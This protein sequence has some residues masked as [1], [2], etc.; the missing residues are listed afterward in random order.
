MRSVDGTPD[1]IELP[2]SPSR[3]SP[4]PRTSSSGRKRT[5]TDADIFHDGD[6]SDSDEA[7]NRPAPRANPLT[8]QTFSNIIKPNGEERMSRVAKRYRLDAA[9]TTEL[10]AFEK[11]MFYV[12]RCRPC[13]EFAYTSYSSLSRINYFISSHNSWS[14][15][16]RLRV[17]K[18]TQ[19]KPLNRLN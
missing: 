10:R 5:H 7:E 4:E 19:Y 11:V 6:D 17:L 3:S 8:T 13:R 1:G 12:N 9:Q 15:E 16:R 18:K 14:K 2:Q